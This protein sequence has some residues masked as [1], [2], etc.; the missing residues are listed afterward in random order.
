M[1]VQCPACSSRFRVDVQRHSGKRITIRCNRC[2]EV[3]KH[4]I[5]SPVSPDPR[6]RSAGGSLQVLVAHHDRELC[7]MISDLLLKEGIDCATCHDGA[8]ALQRMEQSP[9]QVAVMDV[10]LPGLFAFEVVDRVRS[11]PGL[12]RVKVILLSSV[13]NKTAY[14]RTPNSL[15]GADDYIEK[16]HI[17]VTLVSKIRRLAGNGAGTEAAATVEDRV[18]IDAVNAKIR[19]AEEKETRLDSPGDA[20]EKARR[21]ARIIVSDIALYNQELVEEGIRDGQFYTHLAEQIEEGRRLFRSRVAP[22]LQGREDFLQE[23]FSAFIDR[24]RREM[25]R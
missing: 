2:Q 17:P 10:A 1:I 7:T 21:L 15:Y 18:L 23:A 24:R 14:K 16:H 22:D 4:S 20:V 19:H 6:G 5:S 9:P 11:R 25:E 12:D 13:Y 8:S 3:F